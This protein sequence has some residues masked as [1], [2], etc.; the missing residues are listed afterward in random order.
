MQW[1]GV[2]GPRPPFAA[3]EG[4]EDGGGVYW[5]FLFFIRKSVC[6]LVKMALIK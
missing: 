3:V 4:V 5:L 1:L 6:V 2:R